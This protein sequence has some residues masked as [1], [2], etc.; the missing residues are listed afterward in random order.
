MDMRKSG[1]VS[2]SDSGAFSDL[3]RLNQ[4]ESSATRTATATCAR[5]RR[6][7]SRCSSTRCSSRCA[8]PPKCPGQGQPA[9]HSGGQAV[10]GNVRPAVGGLAVSR[11]GGGIGLADVLLR[12][13]SKE[14]AA[15]EGQ[16]STRQ[17]PDCGREAK[18]DV[19]TTTAA[20]HPGGWP[21]GCV[22]MASVPLW[23]ARV[24]A[25]A[26]CRGRAP[27]AMTWRC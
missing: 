11:Q 13:M 2:G 10:S 15:V 4:L 27:C 22:P 20:V 19:P 16:A 26:A 14:Q 25:G 6:S 8:R 18:V 3:N 12:Q 7:S 1:V 9:E 5:W 21:V 23:A 24:E 17:G